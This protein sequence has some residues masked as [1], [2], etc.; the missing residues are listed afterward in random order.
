MNMY[1]ILKNNY[2]THVIMFIVYYV[3]IIICLLGPIT[4][5]RIA[6]DVYYV[7]M[8]LI[9]LRTHLNIINVVFPTKFWLK[10]SPT[11]ELSSLVRLFWSVY[12]INLVNVPIASPPC[13][14][15]IAPYVKCIINPKTDILINDWISDY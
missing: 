7:D 14:Y 10:S 2:S 5:T 12:L 11:N 13:S 3:Q 6:F 4:T 1:I 8:K 15:F 9:K